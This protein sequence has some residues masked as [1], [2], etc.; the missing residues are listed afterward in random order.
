MGD[1]GRKGQQR[2]RDPVVRRP[3]AY[4]GRRLTPPAAAL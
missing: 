2:C 1:A 3:Q 4:P